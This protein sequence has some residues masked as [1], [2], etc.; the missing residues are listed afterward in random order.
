MS[1]EAGLTGEMKQALGRFVDLL[2][3]EWQESLVS[4]V[5]FGSQARG[6]ATAESDID[7]LIVRRGFSRNRLERRREMHGII[8]RLPADFRDRLSLVLL[9]PEEAADTKPFYLDM[10][11]SCEI[12]FDRDGFFQGVLAGLKRRLAELNSRRVVDVDGNP[13]WILKPDARLGEEIVL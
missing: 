11:F 1:G 10:L 3:E 8:R 7:L 4:V 13:Y 12:L 9:T 6:A 2:C 5:L